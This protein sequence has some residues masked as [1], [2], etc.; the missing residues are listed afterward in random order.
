MRTKTKDIKKKIQRER[1]IVCGS[2][3]E[4]LKWRW[5]TDQWYKSIEKKKT[6][7]KSTAKHTTYTN[8]NDRQHCRCFN[9]VRQTSNTL[10]KYKRKTKTKLQTL[11]TIE[12]T[13]Y[14]KTERFAMIHISPLHFIFEVAFWFYCFD[15]SLSK[16][17]YVFI[18]SVWSNICLPR[19]WVTIELISI[20]N[21]NYDKYWI[22]ETIR[23]K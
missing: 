19:Y 9:Q 3:I 11:F 18:S 14:S 23:L 21:K 4:K 20:P 22:S 2:E 12:W 15:S 1:M 13:I 10:H 6:R 5:C 17:M 7:G 16:K 8:T